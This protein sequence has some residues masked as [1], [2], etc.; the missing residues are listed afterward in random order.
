M[1]ERIESEG[2]FEM[3]W[4]CD[5]CDAKRF[6]AKSQRHCAECGAP[7][8]PDKRYFP[9][10]G[11]EKRVDG[12]QYE[13]ADRQCPA[14]NTPQSAKGKNCTQCGAPLDGAKEVRGVVTAAPPPKKRR[15]QWIVL[16]VV[17]GIALIVF[18][19]WFLFLRTKS[20]QMMVTAHR[21]ERAIGVEQFGE[22]DGSNWRDKL[23]TDALDVSCRHKER[24]TRKV[25]TGEEDCH[26]E[27]KDKKDGTYE[28]IKKCT[29]VV[30]NEPVEDDWCSYTVRRWRPLDPVKTTGTGM[31]PVWPTASL[32]PLKADDVIGA[33]RQGKR[34]ENWLLDLGGQ[35]CD[36]SEATW[37][38]YADGQAVNVQVRASSGAIVCSSL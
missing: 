30:R 2:H 35:S 28:V 1:G 7:Q 27:R 10:P 18:G 38:K 19:I 4:D 15:R 34:S 11:E 24:S 16:A 5:H 37:K 20:A 6:L 13:G 25:D 9:P 32:P 33:M 3:L 23:P 8:N 22:T 26:T 36:V 29:P 31:S 12:H 14:C 17:V 21:W